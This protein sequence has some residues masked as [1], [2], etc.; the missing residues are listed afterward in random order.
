MISDTLFFID[1]K[2]CN[3]LIF[4]RALELIKTA[5]TRAGGT[6]N[7]KDIVNRIQ[8]AYD[9][10][11]KDNDFIY[12]ERIPDIKS[13]PP[14]GKAVIVKPTP[15]TVPLSSGFKGIGMILIL[16]LFKPFPCLTIPPSTFHLLL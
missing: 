12:H 16:F 15:L 3:S 5:E 2:Y 6:N 9:E 11:K 14:I 8:R 7:F 13:L 1:V 4:Q 10:A